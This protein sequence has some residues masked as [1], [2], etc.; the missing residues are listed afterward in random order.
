[1]KLIIP[2]LKD[3]SGNRSRKKRGGDERKKGV[4]RRA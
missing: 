2:V 4:G 3:P 1:M